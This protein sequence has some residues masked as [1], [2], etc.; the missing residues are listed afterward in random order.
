MLTTN[1]AAVR[2]TAI[3]ALV[4]NTVPLEIASQAL[5]IQMKEGQV[6]MVNV[7]LYLQ[8]TKIVLVPSLEAVV[9]SMDTVDQTQTFAMLIIVTL[10]IV[11]AT[12]LL[13][14]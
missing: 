9:P 14:R 8:V 6:Q 4:Q 1:L 3:A 5:V 10:E 11:I 7:D 12:R 13:R 2:S